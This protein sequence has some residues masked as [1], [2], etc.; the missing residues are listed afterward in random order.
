MGVADSPPPALVQL[1]VVCVCADEISV[2]FGTSL[3]LD[4]QRDISLHRFCS[5]AAMWM[6]KN[7][8]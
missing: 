8:L 6:L 7:K 3:A 1:P 5:T 2:A 4:L